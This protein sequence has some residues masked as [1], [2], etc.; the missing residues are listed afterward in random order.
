MT[1][2]VNPYYIIKSP[3]ITE[4]STIQTQSNNQYIFKVIPGANKIQ[5]KAAVEYLFP[6]VK[7]VS[8]NTMNYIGKRRR[9]GRDVGFKSNWKKAI[10][11]LRDGDS[12][13]LI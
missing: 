3:V 1:M 11:K 13:D 9:R 6:N 2:K 7:V 12:I 10:V 4:E 5:I 8:V